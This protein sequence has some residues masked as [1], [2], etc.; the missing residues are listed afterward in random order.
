MAPVT[1]ADD[2]PEQLKLVCLFRA[3]DNQAFTAAPSLNWE[4]KTRCRSEDFRSAKATLT[5]ASPTAMAPWI[6]KDP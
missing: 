6:S 3:S 1:N 2:R 5:S 4:R